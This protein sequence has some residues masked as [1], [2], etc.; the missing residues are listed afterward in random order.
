MNQCDLALAL[1]TSDKAISQ[2]VERFRKT[3]MT[4]DDINEQLSVLLHSVQTTLTHHQP[5]GFTA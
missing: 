2:R 4:Q 5:K 1:G 3:G